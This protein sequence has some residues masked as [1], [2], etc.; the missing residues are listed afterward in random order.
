MTAERRYR[1]EGVVQGVG[2]RWWTR[3]VAQRLGL[4][5]TVRN[6]PDGSVEVR[7]RGETDL[8]ERLAAELR[9]GPPGATVDAV[10]EA[11]DANVP[12]AG[13]DITR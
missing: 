8:L 11:P 13:F 6:L 3:A 5:G 12:T 10:A 2:F 1:V 9:Q 4:T 7:A